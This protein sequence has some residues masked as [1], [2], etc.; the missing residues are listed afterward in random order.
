MQTRNQNPTIFHALPSSSKKR[1]RELR[2][3][4]KKRHKSCDL[5]NLDSSL[6]YPFKNLIDVVKLKRKY[7]RGKH[8]INCRHIGDS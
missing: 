6:I 2:A 7:V 1:D 3:R 5:G 8:C 4:K